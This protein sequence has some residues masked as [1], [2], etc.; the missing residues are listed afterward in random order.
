MLCED[1]K[2][3]FILY[4]RI[5]RVKDPDFMI[6]HFNSILCI[7]IALQSYFE[8]I[9]EIVLYTESNSFVKNHL[10]YNKVTSYV[11]YIPFEFSKSTK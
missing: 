2:V 10:F 5:Y 3:K 8:V 9:V 11:T 4:P 6:C 7:Q 1:Y